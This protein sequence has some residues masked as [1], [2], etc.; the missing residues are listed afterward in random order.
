MRDDIGS[1]NGFLIISIKDT[2]S[3]FRRLQ[4]P[5]KSTNIGTGPS[6]T[7]QLTA[8][9]QKGGIWGIWITVDVYSIIT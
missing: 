6:G 5:P 7:M 8:R 4:A 2:Y 1:K 3:H 9:I